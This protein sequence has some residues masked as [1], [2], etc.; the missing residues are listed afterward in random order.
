MPVARSHRDTLLAMQAYVHAGLAGGIFHI[1]RLVGIGV[2]LWLGFGIET[3][4]YAIV[5][6]R[7]SEIL[8]CR[9][10]LAIPLAGGSMLLQR[11]TLGVIGPVFIYSMA[12]RAFGALDIL[13]LSG[14]AA[15]AVALS[16]YAA[17]QVLAQIPGLIN[18]VLVP[19]LIAAMSRAGKSGDM[20]LK[21]EI[22][23]GAVRFIAVVS[24]LLV[25]ACGSAP[26]ILL[27]I[28]G[29]PYVDA[30]PVFALLIASGIGMLWISLSAA[31]LVDAGRP[32]ASLFAVAPMVLGAVV[33]WIVFIPSYAETGAAV[34][35]AL[36]SAA[37]ALSM[38]LLLGKNQAGMLR[39]LAHGLICGAA[40]GLVSDWLT[41]RAYPG[42]DLLA[43]STITGLLMI[44]S[45]LVDKSTF[46]RFV[47][48]LVSNG[49]NPT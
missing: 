43:G 40:G 28:F 6:G 23:H 13:I 36:C 31:R 24:G 3:V 11:K 38:I 48:G 22:E 2:F 9:T 46:E 16:H 32:W 20:V 18:L 4:M 25:V 35:S 15:N 41:T 12:M 5:L 30:A 49:H 8:W 44:V 37:A 42:V 17:A 1:A 10:K 33:L 39:S 29:R 7:I 27:V 47:Y 19:G 14:L 45:G 26:S 34:I 21:Q